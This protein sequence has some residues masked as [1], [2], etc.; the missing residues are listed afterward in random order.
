MLEKIYITLGLGGVILLVVGLFVLLPWLSILAV[1]QVFGTAIQLTFWNW[2][3]V[4]WLHIVVAST[5]S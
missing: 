5:R 1:N 2:L 3:S 4:V